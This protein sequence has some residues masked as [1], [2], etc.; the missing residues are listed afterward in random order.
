VWLYA[1]GCGCRRPSLPRCPS[2]APAR[3][4]PQATTT[5]SPQPRSNLGPALNPAAIQAL[6]DCAARRASGEAAATRQQTVDEKALPHRP[7]G[8]PGPQ[9][10]TNFFAMD[11]AA[12]GRHTPIAATTRTRDSCVSAS[13]ST[14]SLRARAAR[15]QAAATSKLP[16]KKEKKERPTPVARRALRGPLQARATDQASKPEP[17]P[18]QPPHIRN[19][20][21]PPKAADR[22]ER[23]FHAAT[24]TAGDSSAPMR[25]TSALSCRGGPGRTP[26]DV[27]A[28]LG[29][30]APCLPLLPFPTRLPGLTASTALT[31]DTPA[32]HPD[33]SPH[34]AAQAEARAGARRNARSVL[35]HARAAR[36][37]PVPHPLMGPQQPSRGPQGGSRAGAAAE[38]DCHRPQCAFAA[39]PEL[40]CG[41]LAYGGGAFACGAGPRVA[42]KCKQEVKSVDCRS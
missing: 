11:G 14:W 12:A 36:R 37:L 39:A 19:L 8:R 9:L 40:R 15:A 21:R 18:Q 27:A 28:R 24:P 30:T 6:A 31:P 35:P 13:S 38:Q 20:Q 1:S 22:P 26:Q 17:E 2:A 34:T 29:N 41:R 25:H 32:G 42:V 4:R 5:P 3:A 16:R 10:L 7:C 33:A 23:A